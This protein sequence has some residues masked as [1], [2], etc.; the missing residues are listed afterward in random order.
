M[1]ER[2][3]FIANRIRER[4]WVK[5]LLMCVLSVAAAF[6]ARAADNTYLKD[7]APDISID[8]LETLLS[9]IA[10]S[11]LVIA[12][13]AVGSMVTA[14]ASASNTA[15]PRSFAL[16][17]ADDVSQN[18][19]SAFVG[20]FIY[21]IVALIVLQNSYYDSGGRFALFALTL[22]V[23]T[24][25]ILMFVRWVD[26]IARLGRMGSTIEKVE[27]ATASALQQFMAAPT[28]GCES[29]QPRLD[30]AQAVYGHTIGYVT[31]IDLPALQS[32]AEEA[33][34]QIEIAALPGTFASPGRPLA[35]V[36]RSEMTEKDLTPDLSEVANTFLIGRNR[37]FDDD[38]RFGLVVLSEIGSRALSPGINDPGTAINVIGSFIRL[39]SL[40][41]ESNGSSE[42]EG[43]SKGKVHSV[44]ESDQNTASV[45]IK[46]NR[47][48]M[49][50]LSM[51]DLFDDAF[52]AIC[53]DGAGHI[54]VVTW[55]LKTFESL[56]LAGDQTMREV[57]VKY[58]HNVLQRAEATM[59]F[60][61]DRQHA[62]SAAAFLDSPAIKV[63]SV[64]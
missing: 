16:V 51:D 44:K 50:N 40:L 46:Y 19:L 60:E 10:S 20:A 43:S 18:A 53:R 41:C 13:F 1:Y 45:D 54:E 48:S 55:I 58:A 34:V 5:P 56:I 62:R 39:F 23:F 4:L 32:L 7:I 42:W 17:V 26:R 21:S 63:S 38:P 29:V 28:L 33:K 24:V 2:L 25:V 37:T 22:F 64:E 15:T 11:M 8:S 14:Y 12:T 61:V 9:I 35:F 30:N 59:E 6:L 31:R 49:P 52:G 47:L 27:Q 3:C 36:S 57:A